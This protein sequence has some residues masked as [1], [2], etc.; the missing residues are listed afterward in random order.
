MTESTGR[1]RGCNRAKPRYTL[2]EHEALERDLEV[3]RDRLAARLADVRRAYP[4]A[5]HWALGYPLMVRLR[6]AVRKT[7]E[8]IMEA[9]KIK[10]NDHPGIWR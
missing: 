5:A 2:E 9:E 7:E 8:A 10:Y 4:T 6:M 3:L 1:G